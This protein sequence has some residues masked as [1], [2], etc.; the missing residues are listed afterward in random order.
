MLPDQ[1]PRVRLQLGRIIQSALSSTGD[2]GAE[3]TLSSPTLCAVF[4]CGDPSVGGTGAT[5]RSASG[6]M[7]VAVHT[8][9]GRTRIVS[10]SGSPYEGARG[11][12]A[13]TAHVGFLRGPNKCQQYGHPMHVVGTNAAILRQYA[14][15]KPP[16]GQH[17]KAPIWKARRLAD[18]MTVLGWST[19]SRDLN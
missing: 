4:F 13:L 18:T 5:L 8:I 9:M 15:R 10:L 14:E 7:I 3:V 6:T 1:A 19:H 2:M 16:K 12:A 17:L 11:D